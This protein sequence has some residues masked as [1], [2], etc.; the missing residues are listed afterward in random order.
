MSSA[1]KNFLLAVLVLVRA[2]NYRKVFILFITMYEQYSK[3]M[4]NN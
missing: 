2:L 3:A 1:S 4:V